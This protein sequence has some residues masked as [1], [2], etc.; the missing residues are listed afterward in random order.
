MHIFVFFS[1]SATRVCV[2]KWI[3][4]LLRPY[5]MMLQGV[6]FRCFFFIHQKAFATRS[7]IFEFSSTKKYNIVSSAPL[8]RGGVG[9]AFLVRTGFGG[10]CEHLK[11]R[12][13]NVE[14]SFYVNSFTVVVFSLFFCNKATPPA[15]SYWHTKRC[16]Y[17]DFLIVKLP[18][19]NRI[20]NI[21]FVREWKM[22]GIIFVIDL[23]KE[24]KLSPF[25]VWTLFN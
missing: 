16:F 7:L 21:P 22:V 15:V 8:F 23:Q 17:I 19:P 3:A 25:F 24:L 6:Q 2:N 9:P 20:T 1:Q 18:K 12:G 14:W 11:I 10:N 13:L 5:S 4:K